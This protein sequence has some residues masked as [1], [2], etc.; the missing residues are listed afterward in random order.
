VRRLILGLALAALVVVTGRALLET[1]ADPQTRVILMSIDT[2][3]ADRLGS[4]GYQRP[5]SP[6]LDGLAAQGVRF[7]NA[8]APSAWTMPSHASLLTGLYPRSHGVTVTH[9][10]LPKDV[11]RLP[12]LLA[13][14]GFATGATV[15]VGLI[16]SN[17]GFADGFGSFSYVPPTEDSEGTAPAV[18]ERALEWLRSQRGKPAFLFVHYYDVHSDYNPAQP[19]RDMFVEPY[20]GGL[21]GT[22]YQL[23]QVR[24]GNLRLGPMDARHL[25]NLYDAGIRQLDDELGRFFAGLGSLERTFVVIVSDHGEE[26]MDHGS[27]GHGRTLYEE[28]V[29][30]PLIVLGPGIPAGLVVEEPVSLVD[31]TPTLLSLV[32][33]AIP[34]GLEGRDLSHLWAS[35]AEGDRDG[36]PVFFEAD[37]W[38][39]NPKKNTRRAIRRGSY[40]L[41]TESISEQSELYDLS[42]DPR[43]LE[44]LAERAPDVVVEMRSELQD[45]TA[46]SRPEGETAE[47]SPAELEQLRNLGYVD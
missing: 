42:R 24:I 2:L 25:S 8:Y 29:R 45:F 19:Y 41:H 26:F 35:A 17:R 38:Y 7:T 6:V 31:V 9:S 11:P 47:L 30:V 23:R 46:G 3:R 4:Y 34:A 5:T 1:L 28:L 39:H 15:N 13:E 10:T 16:G 22:S 33:A 36:L 18:N 40:K 27:V 21:D 32:G 44:N 20:R 12:T 14:A 43:E 37:Q